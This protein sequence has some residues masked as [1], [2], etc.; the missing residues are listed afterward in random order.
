V[1]LKIGQQPAQR[2]PVAGFDEVTFEPFLWPRI[3]LANSR[4]RVR[5]IDMALHGNRRRGRY[6]SGHGQL[7]QES[8]AFVPMHLELASVQFDQASCERQADSKSALRCLKR[9]LWTL[10]RLCSYLHSR[11]TH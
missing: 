9:T 7:H 4:L 8:A 1:R 2:G 11:V 5:A 3:D 6:W 10:T